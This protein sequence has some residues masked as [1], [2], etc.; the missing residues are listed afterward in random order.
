MPKRH[1]R[2]TLCFA[3]RLFNRLSPCNRHFQCSMET[4]GAKIACSAVIVVALG[5]YMAYGCIKKNGK[6]F[7][8]GVTAG[9]S[10]VLAAY[11]GIM[12]NGNVI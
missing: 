6:T 5:G 1:V 9:L 2:R 11:Y 3:P 8:Q 10:L 12:L 4:C 7:P